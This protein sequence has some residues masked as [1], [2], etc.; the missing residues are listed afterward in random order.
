MLA[1]G[2]ELSGRI[3]R[4]L[5]NVAIPITCGHIS[6]SPLMKGGWSVSNQTQVFQKCGQRTGIRCQLVTE[7]PPVC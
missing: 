5:P 6:T 7:R 4:A 2:E 1:G 3:V